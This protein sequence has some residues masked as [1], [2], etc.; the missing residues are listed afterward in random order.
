MP[1]GTARNLSL[2][3]F[4][5]GSWLATPIRNASS[6]MNVS[7]RH[8]LTAVTAAAVPS[9]SS[10]LLLLKQ[11]RIHVAYR[12]PRVVMTFLPARSRTELIGELFGT[13]RRPVAE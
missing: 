2:V 7:A 13:S 12:A 1:H 8:S 4:S 10:R 11:F 9:T 3:S 5:V 6:N